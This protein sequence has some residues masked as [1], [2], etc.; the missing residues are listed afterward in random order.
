MTTRR[1]FLGAASSLAFSNLFSPAPR[2]DRL[3]HFA[4][5]LALPGFTALATF[6]AQR[7]WDMTPGVERMMATNAF[8]E[9]LGF[10]SAF[11]FVAAYD[12]SKGAG[13]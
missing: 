12:L 6:I 5:V 11:F 7:L 10:A 8:F 13:K 3:A 9:R 4:G 2:S 1:T